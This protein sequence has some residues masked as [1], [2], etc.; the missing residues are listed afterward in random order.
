MSQEDP[1][2]VYAFQRSLEMLKEGKS[3]EEVKRFT[4]DY[5]AEDAKDMPN[6]RQE[7]E[8]FS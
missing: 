2:M 5:F 7:F 1:S 8:Q 3:P 4:A 6:Y